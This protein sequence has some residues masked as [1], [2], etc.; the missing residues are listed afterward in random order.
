MTMASGQY[1]RHLQKDFLPRALVLNGSWHLFFFSSWKKAKV[2]QSTQDL[3]LYTVH[4]RDIYTR[5]AVNM[6][7]LPAT[8]DFGRNG[9]LCTFTV[10]Y[11]LSWK[12]CKLATEQLLPGQMA[13]SGSAAGSDRPSHILTGPSFE[14]QYRSHT[15]R[16]I[17]YQLSWAQGGY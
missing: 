4:R 14:V 7:S 15:C 10:L 16:A 2:M 1:Y 8:P 6:E 17:L 3:C 12:F 5:G 13:L 9:L 11:N